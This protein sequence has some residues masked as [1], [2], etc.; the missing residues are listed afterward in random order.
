[1]SFQVLLDNSCDIK[2]ESLTADGMGGYTQAY[3]VLYLNVKCRF[4]ST[5]RKTEILALGGKADVYPDYYVYLEYRSGIAEGDHIIFES[6]TFEVKLV[7]D[8]SERGKYMRLSVVELK[9]MTP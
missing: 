3:A 1:M 9:R 7:E 6:R 8:W 5:S 4:E 2:R